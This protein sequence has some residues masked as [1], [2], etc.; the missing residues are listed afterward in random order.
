MNLKVKTLACEYFFFVISISE[1]L[2][3]QNT[4][5]EE[6]HELPNN[7]RAQLWYSGT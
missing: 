5:H 1:D 6:K 4:L 2:E 7:R 3:L